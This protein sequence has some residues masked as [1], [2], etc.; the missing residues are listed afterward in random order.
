M[1]VSFGVLTTRHG[2]QAR[3]RVER[4]LGTRRGS[5]LEMADVFSRMRGSV[6]AAKPA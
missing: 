2:E 3:A 5:A 1:P 6:G 4:A